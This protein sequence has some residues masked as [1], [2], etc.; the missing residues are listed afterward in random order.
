MAVGGALSGVQNADAGAEIGGQ[1]LRRK[2]FANLGGD[3]GMMT[4]NSAR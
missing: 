3:D 1:D 2:I 4:Q